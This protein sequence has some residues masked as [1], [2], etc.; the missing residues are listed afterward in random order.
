MIKCI[1]CG[2]HRV[3]FSEAIIKKDQG[4]LLVKGFE[5][6]E[7]QCG[8]SLFQNGERDFEKLFFGKVVVDARLD[9]NS[10]IENPIYTK[11]KKKS[12]SYATTAVQMCPPIKQL[13]LN[14]LSFK[15][16]TVPCIL[17]ARTVMGS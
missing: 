5:A 2:K 12:I 8:E 6:L 1:S 4:P 3:Y 17:L 9:C 14:S 15:A 7:F 16:N 10:H 13:R 11:F